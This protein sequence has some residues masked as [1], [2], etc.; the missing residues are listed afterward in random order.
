MLCVTLLSILSLSAPLSRFLFAG[1]ST[2]SLMEI[3]ITYNLIKLSFAGILIASGIFLRS[4]CEFIH[5]LGYLIL[6]TLWFLSGRTIGIMYYPD[7][8]VK[9]GWHYI[10]TNEFGLCEDGV[11]CEL[12]VNKLTKIEKLPF[13]RIRITNSNTNEVLFTGPFIWNQTVHIFEANSPIR[14]HHPMHDETH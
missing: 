6:L 12:Q 11:N 5:F 13:W 7:G 2:E 4:K 14:T 1:G 9:T 3:A 8:I 10:R